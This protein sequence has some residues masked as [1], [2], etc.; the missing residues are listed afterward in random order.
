MLSNWGNYDFPEFS[1]KLR[2]LKRAGQCGKY[3]VEQVSGSI[4]VGLA[5]MSAYFRLAWATYWDLVNHTRHQNQAI[6]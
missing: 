6:A 3:Q 5:E 4:H 1:P 2:K